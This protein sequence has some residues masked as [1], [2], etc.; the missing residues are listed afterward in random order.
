MAFSGAK[1]AIY[2]RIRREKVAALVGDRRADLA[3]IAAPVF[4][5]GQELVGA[6][7]LTM[8]A[9]RY[10]ESHIAPVVEAA[11]ILTAKLGGTL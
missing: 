9:N 10:K 11:R 4:R 1:G 3:G 7:T 5:A 2:D 6:I 8:P